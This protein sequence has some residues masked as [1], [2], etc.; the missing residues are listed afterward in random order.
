MIVG[1]I[2][3]KSA[4][5]AKTITGRPLGAVARRHNMN[6][7]MVLAAALG[8]RKQGNPGVFMVFGREHLSGTAEL[9]LAVGIC[10]FFRHI[11]MISFLLSL[12]CTHCICTW[13]HTTLL[14]VLPRLAPITLAT[15]SLNFALLP[16]HGMWLHAF[17]P[18]SSQ[19]H[20]L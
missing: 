15:A 9:P 13:A 20:L 3:V 14:P 5:Q 19:T 16:I 10:L 11:M 7:E 6:M 1:I 17:A 4:L 12:S 2:K 8:G 18:G